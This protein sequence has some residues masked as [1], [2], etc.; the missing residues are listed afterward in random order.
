[1]K[2]F[3]GKKLLIRAIF[4]QGFWEVGWKFFKEFLDK[5]SSDFKIILSEL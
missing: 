1:M 5:N 3:S 2:L 4:F